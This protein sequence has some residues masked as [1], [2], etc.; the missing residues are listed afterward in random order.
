MTSFRKDFCVLRLGLCNGE[1]FFTLVL[2]GP[3]HKGRSHSVQNGEKLTL[4]PLDRK[5]STMAQPFPP[6]SLLQK[7]LSFLRQK[8]RRFA[9]ED[10]PPPCPQNVH[11]GQPP[12]YGRL[13][14]TALFRICILVGG[15]TVRFSKKCLFEQRSISLVRN[16]GSINYLINVA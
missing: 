16:R 15:N 2:F 3:V 6:P 12:D 10:P 1:Y 9:F 8:A 11:T 13:L 7:I 5:M 4:Y 14:R